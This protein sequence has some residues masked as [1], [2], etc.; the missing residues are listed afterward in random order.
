LASKFLVADLKRLAPKLEEAERK[1]KTFS[2]LQ[3]INKDLIWE[4]YSEA[5][6]KSSNLKVNDFTS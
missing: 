1:M 5:V 2:Y 3:D 6:E 4:Y